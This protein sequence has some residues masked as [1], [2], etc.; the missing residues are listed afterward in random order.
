M[1]QKKAL[2]PGIYARIRALK[3]RERQS[4]G[5]VEHYPAVIRL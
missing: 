5:Q 1:N 4:R 3:P 2:I